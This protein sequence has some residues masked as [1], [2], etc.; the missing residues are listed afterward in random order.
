MRHDVF[1]SPV[2]S[3]P[4]LVEKFLRGY[5]RRVK[6]NAKRERTFAF[7]WEIGSFAFRDKGES[8]V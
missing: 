1:V 3:S 4:I 6:K 5:A 8:P 7:V 2:T